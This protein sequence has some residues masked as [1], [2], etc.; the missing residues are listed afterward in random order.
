MNVNYGFLS[1]VTRVAAGHVVG[2]SPL[3]LALIERVEAEPVL[4]V[5]LSRSQ[6][7]SWL[8]MGPA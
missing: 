7:T 4:A 2:P 6:E 1:V 3:L 8:G 5:D